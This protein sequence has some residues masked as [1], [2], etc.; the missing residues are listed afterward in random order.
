MLFGTPA[1][2][3]PLN[4]Y[5]MWKYL[6]VILSIVFA[7]IYSMPNFYGEDPALQLSGQK[8]SKISV[9]QIDIVKKKLDD[10]KLHYI[11]VEQQ[12]DTWL[13]RFTSTDDQLIAQN[14][15]RKALGDNYT[16]AMNLIPATPEWLRSLN[17]DPMKLGLDLR[18]GIHF[19]I[20]IDMK[21]ALS[22][23][24]IALADSFKADLRNEDIRYVSSVRGNDGGVV[25]KFRD[26]DTLSKAKTYLTSRHTN[27][28]FSTEQE[29]EFF[30]LVAKFS[31]QGLI[32][33]RDEAVQQNVT[34]LRNRVNELGVAEPLIQRQGAERIVVQLPGIQDSALAKRILSATASLEFRAGNDAVDPISAAQGRVPAD[35]EALPY[36]GR[37]MVV[38]KYAFVTG[39]ELTGASTGVD[40]NGQP[41]V[42]VQLDGRGGQKM[43]A[44]TKQNVGKPM[45][46]VLIEY[47]QKY[48]G[49]GKPIPNSAYVEKK[50][51]TYATINGVFSNRFQI[52]GLDS[53]AEARELAITL[54]S[55]AL[56]APIQIVEERTISA[57][58]GKDNINAG[59]KASMIGVAAVMVFML[60]YY[61]VFG[62]I[63]NIAVVINI[64]LI[65]A[66]LS[67][68]PGAVLT[69][70]GIA[71]LV[72][73]VGMAVDANVLVYERIKDELRE[74]TSLQLAIER[75]YERALATIADANITT[76]I[77]GL[78]LFG[79]GSGPVRGF[80]LTLSL[81]IPTTVFTAVMVSRALTN[82]IYGGR[83]VKKLWI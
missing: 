83:N 73:T 4:T 65:V 77:A 72:L 36:K 45:A 53:P 79:I 14:E 30:H 40:E 51:A 12:A 67:L 74:G 50:L 28:L 24:E 48:D 49:D 2:P 3:R 63:A 80:A 43:L 35:S 76:L 5:P 15:V 6:I 8:G 33:A 32:A 62:L 55:G 41:S 10:A 57:S 54:R 38:K 18:G 47:K 22:K 75:G 69:L 39:D 17:A 16:V 78:A 42:N 68:V 61:R 56:T 34:I 27:L 60:L 23:K 46:G 25:V 29:G 81:G 19:L 31:E 59:F 71:G 7:L 20:E 26:E 52:S 58:M 82:W 11:K 70:P 21:T 1:A 37:V 9:E 44:H 13:I 64:G 66:C